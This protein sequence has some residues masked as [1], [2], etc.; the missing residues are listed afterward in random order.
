MVWAE[1]ASAPGEVEELAPGYEKAGATWWI[2]TA[3]PEPGWWEGVQARVA[4]G[5]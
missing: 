1:V 2:E 5:V 3:R 4:R